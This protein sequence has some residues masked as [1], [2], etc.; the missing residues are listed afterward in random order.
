LQLTGAPSIAVFAYS[1]LLIAAF[2]ARIAP[3]ARS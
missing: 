2:N 3:T 1:D